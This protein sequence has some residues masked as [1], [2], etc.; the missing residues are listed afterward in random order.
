MK[1][2]FVFRPEPG[3][4]ITADMARASG[5]EVCG[6]PLSA[7]EA[8][9]WEIP[10]PNN[11]DGL[12]IGSANVLR[13]AGTGLKSLDRLPVHAVGETTAEAARAAGFL[14]ARTGRGGLQVL[15]DQLAGRELRLLRLAGEDR[16]PLTLPDGITMETLVVYR[17]VPQALEEAQVDALRNG[18]VAMLHSTTAADRLASECERLGV[19]RAGLDLVV[20]GPRV[21]EACGEGWNSIHTAAA[22]TD[23]DMLALAESLCQNEPRVG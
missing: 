22:P 21:A 2:L 11:F 17:A 5:L 7:I 13:H 20:I 23:A 15:V 16:V 8:V 9:E 18:G 19:D 4:S 12:L 10:G 3:W 1:P 14:V 6:S